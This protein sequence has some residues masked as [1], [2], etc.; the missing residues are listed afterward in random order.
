MKKLFLLTIALCSV[1]PAMCLTRAE[2]ETL[3]DS[4][5]TL[6]L[7][8]AYAPAVGIN[9]EGLRALPEDSVALRCEFYSCLL[10]CYHRLGDYEQALR[11]GELCLDF[12]EQQGDSANLSASLGNL[13]G[14]YS[15]AG[16][17]DVAVRY[18][19]RAIDIERTLLLTDSAHTPKSLAVREAMLGEVLLAQNTDLDRALQLT[20]DALETDR[21]LGRRLQEGMRLAQLGHIYQALNRP[22]EAHRYT[23][24]ALS[25]AKETGN[26]M[27][28]VLCL[29]QLER[30]EQAAELANRYGL[31]KQE[32]EACNQL[33]KI[34]K[35][36]A[37]KSKALNFLE[38]ATSLREQ[39][40]SEQNQ[41]Q[42]TIAQ[43]RYEAF[44][45]EQQIAAQQLEIERKKAHERVFILFAVL[46]LTMLALLATLVILLRKRKKELE[47]EIMDR[48]EQYTR[49]TSQIRNFYGKDISTLLHEITEAKAHSKE[50][51]KLTNREKEIVRLICEG[52]KGKEIADRLGISIRSVNSHK[53]NIFYKLGLSSSVELVRY[54]LEH[55][56]I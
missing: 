10:Y 11:Y 15:S 50:E 42:L 30:Y 12:D 39:L 5:Y 44:R 22:D 52:M 49:L 16:Q 26:R 36:K 38:Q 1:L 47:L 54:A 20:Q 35:S 55:D 3:V 43:V 27:T 8:G 34:A 51:T 21:A 14:I 45:K 25:I 53:T 37:D 19:E 31:K 9:E 4:A 33:Y 32:Y 13:A 46:S 24:Q 18:L 2:V 23:E 29:L 41:R 28:E 56:I 6:A 7:G 17:N 48:D 40:M